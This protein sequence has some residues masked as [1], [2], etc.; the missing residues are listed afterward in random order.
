MSQELARALDELRRREEELR[1]LN[2]ELEDTNRGVVA[3]YAELDETAERLRRA[4][5]TKTRF[6]SN[7]SHEFRT[8]LNSILAIS[9]LLVD[10]ADGDLTPE[11]ERQVGFIRKAAKDLAELVDDLLDIAK[12]EA[13]KVDVRLAELQVGDLFAALRGMLRPLQVSEAVALVFAE[14]SGVPPLV[15][16][17][18]KVA[19]ILRNFIANALKFTEQG[20]VRVSAAPDGERVVFAVAD[21]GIGIPPEHHDRIFQEFGQVQSRLQARATGTGLGLA[22]SKRLAELLGGDVWFVSAPGVGSTFSFGLPLVHP[23]VAATTSED[24]EV[25]ESVA[26]ARQGTGRALIVDDQAATRYVLRALLA[27]IPCDTIECGDGRSGLERAREERPGA[28]FLDLVMPGISGFEVLAALDADPATRGIPVV[29]TTSKV[30]T[31]EEREILARQAVPVLPK[32]LLARPGAAAEVRS[33]L[34]RAGWRPVP[35]A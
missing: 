14:P 13:G 23:S 22:L 7:M 9:R 19:Q 4:D 12:V 2:R 8:P 26:P 17:E 21:T 18:G 16:D 33:A 10:R 31:S 24:D 11:Q 3:L 32:D 30:L 27:E 35:A 20:E 1:Q 34:A 28:I 6:L 15:T 29:I 25:T 5:Q